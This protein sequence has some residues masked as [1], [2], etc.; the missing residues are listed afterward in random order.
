MNWITDRHVLITGGNAG[1]GRATARQLAALGAHVTIACRDATRA[2]LAQRD[3]EASTGTAVNVVELDL[4]SLAHIR[5]AAATIRAALQPIDVLVN[6]AGVAVLGR[7]R[8]ETADGF[9]RQIGVNH[10]GHALLTSLLSDRITERV[11]NVSSAGYAMA[12]HGLDF[13]DLQWNRREYD[14]WAAYGASKL[15]NLYFTWELADRLADRHV[16]VNALHPGFVDTEL[17]YR[18]PEEGGKPKPAQLETSGTIGN[19]DLGA[20]GTPLSADEGARTSV[21]VASDPLL[22]DTTGAYFDDHQ[23]QISDLGSVALD[24]SAS[25]RL[26]RVSLELVGL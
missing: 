6:N 3:I 18:R 14:G 20:L 11:V 7:R 17:G 25:E 15:A 16:T 13:D 22:S 10:L 23:H 12:R 1:I 21:A 9:E 4:A 24:R 2:A 19:I 5:Q 26:W 8:R